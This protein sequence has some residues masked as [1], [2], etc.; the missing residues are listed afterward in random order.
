MTGH[1]IVSSSVC[2]SRIGT[3]CW[4]SA[5][6]R[7]KARRRRGDEA[8]AA[9]AAA[10]AACLASTTRPWLSAWVVA[11][12]SSG[13]G[14]CHQS[15]DTMAGRCCRSAGGSNP[16]RSGRWLPPSERRKVAPVELRE[17]HLHLVC[18]TAQR[19][20]RAEVLAGE[21][22]QLVDQRRKLG[23][24]QRLDAAFGIGDRRAVARL[25]VLAPLRSTIGKLWR[26]V[27]GMIPA[28]WRGERMAV[29]SMLGQA[30]EQRAAGDEVDRVEVPAV[31]DDVVR[32]R[33]DL[34]DL[35][36]EE[37]VH[38]VLHGRQQPRLE[39]RSDRLADPLA[40]SEHP[41]VGARRRRRPTTRRAAA[42]SSAWP[43]GS[44]ACRRASIAHS[45]S[46]GVPRAAA[47]RRASVGNRHGLAAI[48]GVLGL[49]ASCGA[50]VTDDPLVTEGLAGHQPL[51]QAADRGHDARAAG[52]R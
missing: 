11:V 28:M 35:L 46:C 3:R 19:R 18:G 27:G 36:A 8:S 9:N 6:R 20:D 41:G 31:D 13:S 33:C 7:R 22:G 4:A 39:E 12:A 30:A 47:M 34:A 26:T 17:V 51:A 5:S 16:A 42:P 45:M 21:L 43:G 15:S 10:S 23:D 29:T 25:Q 24:G 1:A 52:L 44:R 14:A 49:A 40:E 38:A 48:D 2:S 37:R 50:T 32:P